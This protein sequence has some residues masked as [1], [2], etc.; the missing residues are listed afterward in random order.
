MSFPKISVI[1]T[2]Y[3]KGQFVGQALQSVM[4]QGYSPMEVI[5]VDDGS[6]DN[7]LKI[8]NLFVKKYAGKIKVFS[9][10][11]KGQISATNLGFSKISGEIVN[12]LNSDD[13]LCKNAFLE[14]GRAFKKEPDLLWLTGYSDIIDKDNKVIYKP[15]TKYKNL[16][17]NINKLA[18]LLIV[19]YIS[20][21]TVFIRRTALNKF[22]PFSNKN[23]VF[24]EY[25][26]WLKLAKV[27]MP[28]IIKKNLAHFRLTSGNLS[29][30]TFKTVLQED[31]LAAKRQ[32]SNQLILFLHLMN[33]FG[34]MLLIR[35]FNRVNN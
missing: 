3:N 33:N 4:D 12:F 20:L 32:T 35:I 23:L 34:R 14:A 6:T 25:D 8:I 30:T 5:V 1:M 24:L 17:L 22:G 2:N 10:K 7:S 21:P 11:N 13:V 19:N 29:L 18:L 27:Q 15:V 16:L 26:L 31:Y 28:K 9:Q